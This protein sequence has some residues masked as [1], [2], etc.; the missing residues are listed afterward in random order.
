MVASRVV[1][2][3]EAKNSSDGES[4]G[5]D[6]MENCKP[7]AVAVAS[8]LT[9]T[10]PVMALQKVA[11]PAAA[12]GV[13]LGQPAVTTK[14]TAARSRALRKR[15]VL[16]RGGEG[17]TQARLRRRGSYTFCTRQRSTREPEDGLWASG[18]GPA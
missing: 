1:P 12:G 10:E 18:L 15:D 13:L 7:S 11:D 17:T 4:P 5:G 6:R 2:G 14:K 8:R 9:T 3:N 16:R